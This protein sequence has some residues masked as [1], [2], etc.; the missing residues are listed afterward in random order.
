MKKA[1]VVV[2]AL[3]LLAGCGLIF[4][5]PETPKLKAVLTAQIQSDR[6]TV[7]LDASKSTG[8]NLTY[9]WDFDDGGGLTEG[10]PIETKRYDV[11][12]VYIVRLCVRGDADTG[13]GAPDEPGTPPWLNPGSSGPTGESWDYEVVDLAVV[14]A[15]VPII[16]AMQFGNV[17]GHNAYTGYITFDGSKSID[18]VGKGLAYRWEITR[19]SATPPGYP[20]FDPVYSDQDSVTVWLNSPYCSGTGLGP[21]LYRAKLI[22]QDGNM[23]TVEEVYDLW[24]W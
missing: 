6:K 16:I 9:F 14:N 21:W 10:Q 12:G 17:I 20:P 7:V 3:F 2:S 22:I 13:S 15:P 1:I 23:Q 8:R 18:K 4:Q 5:Q 24:V 19:I 11:P